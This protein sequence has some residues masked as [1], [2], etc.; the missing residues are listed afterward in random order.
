MASAKLLL[1]CEAAGYLPLRQAIA[2]YVG[3]ARG[4]TCA[5]EQVAIVSGMLEA[6][7]LSARLLVEPGEPVAMES[8]GYT[9]A[10]LALESTGVRIA[11]V[12]TD[13][14]GLVIDERK[15][16]GSRLVYDAAGATSTRWA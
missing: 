14:E 11:P 13:D 7:A 4:V 9:G 5:P 15:L 16:K 2:D 1:G 10:R 12:P 3:T 6:L 8:P